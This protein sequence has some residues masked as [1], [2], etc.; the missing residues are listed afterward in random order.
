MNSVSFH[1]IGNIKIA[2]TWNAGICT[3]FPYLLSLICSI[4]QNNLSTFV[5]HARKVLIS[6]GAKFNLYFTRY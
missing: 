1:T 3:Y 4:M 2:S 6:S 5:D